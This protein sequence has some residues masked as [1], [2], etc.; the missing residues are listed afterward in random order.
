MTV[1]SDI[2]Q[3]V[4]NEHTLHDSVTE[5][6]CPE[7]HHWRTVLCGGAAGEDRDIVECSGCGR[8]VNVRCD[9]DEDYA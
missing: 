5:G 9:F 6:A 4:K 3:R 8:Q 7:G 1:P 2:E